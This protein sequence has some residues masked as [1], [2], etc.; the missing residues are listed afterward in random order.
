MAQPTAREQELLELLNRFRL[1]PAQEL[2]LLIN[3]S[4]PDVNS[5]ISYFNVNKTELANQWSTLVAAQ[6]LAWS[7]AINDVAAVHNSLMISNDLQSHG[8]PGEASLG[9]R[10]NS[11]GYTSWT[12]Y[13]ENV[14]AFATSVFHAHAG[15][16][17]DW[18]NTPTGIQTPAGHRNNMMNNNFREVGLSITSENNSSTSVGPLVVTQDFG[19]RQAL[20]NKGYILGVAYRDFDRDNFYDAGEGLRD[21]LINVTRLNGTSVFSQNLGTMDAGGYQTLLDPGKYL[22]RYF[23]NGSLIKSQTT[24]INATNASNVKIDLKID[25]A[26]VPTSGKGKIVG[27]LFNDLN[28]NGV[29]DKWEPVQS[30]WKVFLDNN[31]NKQLDIG[32]V[33]V[34]T[35][36]NG[37][38][39]FNN[40]A[41]GTYQVA[42]VLPPGWKQTLPNPSNPVGYE[43]YKLDDGAANGS[44]SYSIGDM[45]VFNA[46]TAKSAN[47]IINSISV[48]L[49]SN[50]NPKAV[51]L[52]KDLNG[53]NTPDGNEKILELA[54]NFTGSSGFGNIPITPTTVSGT[55]FV[56]ALYQ[57]NGSTNTWVP[58]DTDSPAGKSWV[59]VSNANSFNPSSFSAFS[60]TGNNWLLR[61]NTSGASSQTITVKANQTISQVNFGNQDI[62]NTTN[63]FIFVNDVLWAEGNSGSTNAAFTVT[64]SNVSSQVVTVNYATANKTASSTNDYIS[65]SGILTFNP[66]EIEKIINVAV[67]G[68]T[69]SEADETFLLNL[70]NPTNSFIGDSQGVGIIISDDLPAISI[71]DK[72]VVEGKDIKAALTVSL[73]AP[74]SQNVTVN[75]STTPGTTTANSDYTPISGTLTFNAGETSKT[76]NLSILNDSINEVDEIVNV[77]LTSPTNAI[78]SKATAKV[79]I[80]DTLKASTTT[81]LSADVENL[82]LTGT[83]AVNGTG[84][85]GNNII[86][87]NSG[88]NSLSGLDG[89][90]NLTGG[91]GKDSLTGGVGIDKFNYT[92]LADSLLNN[93]DLITDFNANTGNDLL[94]VS[95]AREGFSNAGV[96][97]SLDATGIS[98]QLNN[99]NFGVNFA[100]QFTFGARTFV[101]INDSIAGFNAATDAII[102]ITGL[103]GAM[104]INNFTLV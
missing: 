19:N 16:A 42:E 50:G 24:T 89:N 54:T 47:E 102:E 72:L 20:N 30:G 68:D 17:V 49:S 15:F 86:I 73:N 14:Y 97:A 51:Y 35:D 58:R 13:G 60:V 36:I 53:N 100:A 18:G 57:G 55:F 65:T 79:T 7:S 52:Y 61:A 6:P 93:F 82:T 40:L 67:K 71:T 63:P 78:L 31:S 1:N 21:V 59:A 39:T 12:T 94:L 74:Y 38:Y 64:L 5:A 46:F 2:S 43:T 88:N 56:A 44:L 96:V 104:N 29:W 95:T 22:V 48:A 81:I 3:S 9:D 32:E 99:T 10:L 84:N 26:P 33:S 87:G 8:L 92:N 25:V 77:T 28:S 85:T 80:S 76:L 75:Y 37:E 23:R 11:A 101:A 45:M 103:T 41:P 62:N 70:S 4:D 83:G 34:I 27:T 69:T 98:S 91:L 90:D 66:G